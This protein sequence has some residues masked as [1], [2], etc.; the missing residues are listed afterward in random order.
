MV[1]QDPTVMAQNLK[2]ESDRAM[3]VI[4]GS[5]LEDTLRE[6]IKTKFIKI[7]PQELKEL[8]IFNF[9][10][11]VGS[12]STKITMAYALG[13]IEEQ[14]VKEL[15]DIRE[16]RNACAHSFLPINFGTPELANICKRLFSSPQNIFQYAVDDDREKMRKAFVTAFTTLMTVITHGSRAEGKRM[17][18]EQFDELRKNPSLSLPEISL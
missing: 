17:L 2:N 11:P 15:T 18:K 9:D 10:G 16:M 14:T 3:V 6:M 7:E 1:S 12:F 13:I 4:A 8:R 5:L